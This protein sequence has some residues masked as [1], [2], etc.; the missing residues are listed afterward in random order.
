MVHQDDEAFALLRGQPAELARRYRSAGMLQRDAACV[1]GERHPRKRHAVDGGERDAA[2][3]FLAERRHDVERRVAT[4]NE[5]VEAPAAPAKERRR[6]PEPQR[7]AQEVALLARMAAARCQ[8]VV[9]VDDGD[10]RRVEEAACGERV[11][12][13]FE[14]RRVPPVEE[15]AG[16]GQVIDTFRGD[17]VELTIEL[18]CGSLASLR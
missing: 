7:E 13:A 11:E 18:D 4:G 8:I 6:V 3:K 15:I 1:E 16:D 2:A 17:A 10:P 12:G 14:Q 5:T 9:A